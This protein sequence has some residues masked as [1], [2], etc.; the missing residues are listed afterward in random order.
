MNK[1]KRTVMIEPGFNPD[2]KEV[3]LKFK[4]DLLKSYYNNL[5]GLVSMLKEDLPKGTEVT[6]TDDNIATISFPIDGVGNVEVNSNSSSGLVS[7]DSSVMNKVIS[8]ISKFTEMALKA[9][10]KTTEFI[11]LE[12]YPIEELQKDII[13]AVK[14]KR[15]LCIIDTYDSYLNMKNVDYSMPQYFIN[16]GTS[17]YSKAVVLLSSGNLEGLKEIMAPKLKKNA[18]Y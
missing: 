7:I 5:A 2:K 4:S 15:N 6:R 3:Q 13:A 10:L 11:P 9:K 17:E 12:G 8:L 14:A 1:N 18:W 16:A